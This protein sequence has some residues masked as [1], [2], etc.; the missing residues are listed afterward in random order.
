MRVVKILIGGG[1]ATAVAFAVAFALLGVFPLA[2]KWFMNWIRPTYS[3]DSPADQ[4]D[5]VN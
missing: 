4:A 1:V 3:I 5:P 2:T